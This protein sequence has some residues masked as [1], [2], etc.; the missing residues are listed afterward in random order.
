[1]LRSFWAVAFTRVRHLIEPEFSR[2][3]SDSSPK[4]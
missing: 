4:P 2:M 3:A 1:M